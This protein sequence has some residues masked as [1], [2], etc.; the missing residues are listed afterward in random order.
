MLKL[1]QLGLTFTDARGRLPRVGGELAVWQFNFR[2]FRLGDDMY[3]D[4][5]FFLFFFSYSL[6]VLLSSVQRETW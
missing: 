3:V 2:E 4:C 5:F 1:I 6:S